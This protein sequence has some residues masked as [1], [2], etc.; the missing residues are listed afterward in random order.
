MAA[1]APGIH[2]GLV[3]VAE[4][5]HG[6]VTRELLPFAVT[7]NV[8][9]PTAPISH[10]RVIFTPPDV[11]AAA[12]CAG[13]IAIAAAMT[14]SSPNH[15]ARIAPLA[16]SRLLFSTHLVIVVGGRT[17][18]MLLRGNDKRPDHWDRARCRGP[19]HRIG[20]VAPTLGNLGDRPV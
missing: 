12:A 14:E 8:P 7:L 18:R 11:A 10:V 20:R 1:V 6:T 16:P 9:V 19:A 2:D 15:A 5:P 3:T 13:L 17:L 4:P